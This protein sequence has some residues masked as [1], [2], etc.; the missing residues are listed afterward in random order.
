M[1]LALRRR[2]RVLRMS[3]IIYLDVFSSTPCNIARPPKK[4]MYRSQERAAKYPIINPAIARP[5]PCN[6]GLVFI[7]DSAR[8][9][10]ITP[11]TPRTG[12][13]QNASSPT[14]LSTNDQMA[15]GSVRPDGRGG[16]ATGPPAVGAVTAGTPGVVASACG[17]PGGDVVLPAGL[18][19]T[20]G[21]VESGAQPA[22]PSYHARSERLSVP[23]AN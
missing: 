22:A 7:L 18:L 12:P 2:G 13:Q 9:P 4:I 21:T 5:R 16:S 17:G 8:C 1:F 6:S 10:Q 3:P 11:A 15:S 23:A 19:L 20:P 14:K